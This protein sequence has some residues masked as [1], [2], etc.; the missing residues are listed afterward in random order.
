MKQFEVLIKKVE[1][2]KFIVTIFDLET[3]NKAVI[4]TVPG[5]YWAPKGI[6]FAGFDEKPKP[7]GKLVNLASDTRF[8]VNCTDII[9]EMKENGIDKVIMW[10]YL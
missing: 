4:E 5:Y 9:K 10:V 8:R 1:N 2:D 6:E 3:H 7:F